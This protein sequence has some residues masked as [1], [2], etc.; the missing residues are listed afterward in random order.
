MPRKLYIYTSLV[1]F[2][3]LTKIGKK[4][5]ISQSTG[6]VSQ[7]IYIFYEQIVIFV[8]ISLGEYFLNALL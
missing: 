5:R 1:H 3:T 6:F 8:I 2:N 7:N 4:F